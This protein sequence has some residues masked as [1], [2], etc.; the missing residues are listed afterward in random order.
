MNNTTS[1]NFRSPIPFLMGAITL[2]ALGQ[3]FLVQQ[4]L[5]WTLWPGLG[6]FGAAA[7]LLT[8][9][10]DQ[11]PKAPPPLETLSRR[12]EV[13][14]FVLILGLAAFFRLYRLN[15]FPAGIF[16]DEG[17][18][19]IGGL[20]LIDH[21]YHSIIPM[22]WFSG[23]LFVQFRYSLW[24]R[25]FAPTQQSLFLSSILLGLLTLPLVY[26]TF[27]QWAGPRIALIGLFFLAVMRWHISYSR[28][29]H[30]AIQ[31]SLCAFGALAFWLYAL[32]QDKSWAYFFSFFFAVL[33]LYLYQSAK[34]IA[35][36]LLIAAAYESG[37]NPNFKKQLTRMVPA[38][39]LLILLALPI[40]IYMATRGAIT[41]QPGLSFLPQL[42]Q[43][44][45]TFLV[46]HLMD[47]ALMFNRRAESQELHDF[48]DHRMLDDVTGV[49]WLLGF[50]YSLAHLR[51]KKYFY[52]VTGLALMILPAF[53][54]VTANHPSRSLGAAP[55]TAFFAALALGGILRKFREVKSQASLWTGR[56]M[57]TGALSGAAILNFDLYF[58]QQAKDIRC[59]EGPFSAQCSAAG[60]AIAAAGNGYEYYLSSHFIGRDDVNFYTYF[61]KEHL[62]P[63]N[64][65]E[66][67]PELE[68]KP[69]GRGLYFVLEEGQNG[70][71][72]CL[73]SL[74]PGGKTEFF[75]DPQGRALVY[76][77]RIPSGIGTGGTER[78]EMGLSHHFGLEAV[79]RK[80]LDWKA[81]PDLIRQE[82]LINF[83]FRDDF[84]FRQFPPLSIHW[85]GFLETTTPGLYRFLALTT[86]QVKLSVEGK[87]IF[88]GGSEIPGEIYLKRG[89]HRLEF[90]F[91]KASGTDT[92][93][94]L[95]WQKPGDSKF[96]VIPFSAYRKNP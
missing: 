88:S 2:A 12:L 25:L 69:G 94:S 18:E 5:A 70:V 39:F 76:F 30:P 51:Q 58:N 48:P 60:R 72:R 96:E 93:L 87:K 29:A 46:R 89:G 33:A 4:D 82:P 73:Q 3:L 64:L 31:V 20:Q 32:K 84:P 40:G 54:T 55:F 7:I 80:S 65:A 10:L 83:T 36:Y 92:A 78:N 79:Y 8:R 90:F 22:E 66:G 35:P 68:K 77:Y 38:L 71:L 43:E 19:G 67:F 63:L 75:R 52:A 27:R 34:S 24:F 81:P 21:R 44:G 26:W 53:L 95:L 13:F 59:W 86:D 50:L 9:T 74:Y 47:S 61:Q 41:E 37:T 15:E 45:W 28:N 6:L 57:L 14:S 91:Q 17:R 11:T 42:S 49:L 56:L 62:H 16:P 85:D 23:T 1:T